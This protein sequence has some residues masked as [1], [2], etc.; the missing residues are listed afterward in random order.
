MSSAPQFARAIHEASHLESCHISQKR[1]QLLLDL[2]S[3][4]V[5][6]LEIRD[7]LPELLA[8]IRR[9]CECDG[10]YIA[11]LDPEDPYA[12]RECA[13]YPGNRGRFQNGQLNSG[14]DAAW[15]SKLIKGGEP[16]S[17]M[18]TELEAHA[19]A[20]AEGFKSV[21]HLPL[22][23]RARA[24][25]VLTLASLKENAFSDSDIA[26]LRQV[27]SQVAIAVENALAY[28]EIAT[29]K[30]QLACERVYSRLP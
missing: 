8:C 23:S 12:L 19:E 13:Q 24:C 11:L 21:C 1:L 15:V 4:T 20:R 2:T 16:L 28:R 17:L 25:G 6:N 3:R 30:E 26:F 7:L 18:A 14:E 22:I 29:V 9:V 5:S 10:A 27:A